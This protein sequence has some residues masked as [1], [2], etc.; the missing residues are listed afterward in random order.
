MTLPGKAPGVG[1]VHPLTKVAQEIEDIFLGM[2]YT[3]AEGP[4]WR[5]ISSTSKRLIFRKTSGSRHAGFV[6]H[7]GRNSASHAIRPVQIRTMKG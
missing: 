1:A 6:L 3:I 4:G 2:G 7:Y 5:R